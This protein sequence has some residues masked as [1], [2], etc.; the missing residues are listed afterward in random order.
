MAKK[1][2]RRRQSPAQV[3]F[4]VTGLLIILAMVLALI[5]PW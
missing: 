3:I 5:A 2:T 4:A 1:T